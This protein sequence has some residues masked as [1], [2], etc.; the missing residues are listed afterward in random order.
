MDVSYIICA[1]Y[2][3]CRCGF[4]YPC[5]RNSFGLVPGKLAAENWVCVV[6]KGVCNCQRCKD[7]I[8]EDLHK[9]INHANNGPVA[10]NKGDEEEEEILVVKQWRREPYLRNEKE[11]KGPKSY[12]PPRRAAK[13]PQAESEEE[14]SEGEEEGPSPPE[15]QGSQ[16]VSDN[17]SDYVPSLKSHRE[18]RKKGRAKHEPH[19]HLHPHQHHAKKDDSSTKRRA[20]GPKRKPTIPAKPAPVA[21]TPTSAPVPVRST[22]AP[23]KPV[24][25][26]SPVQAFARPETYFYPTMAPYASPQ[27]AYAAA[28]GAEMAARGIPE[29]S[30]P[31]YA[32]PA[33]SSPSL[34]GEYQPASAMYPSFT[35]AAMAAA[36][37][38]GYMPYIMAGG[39][40]LMSSYGIMS[41]DMGAYAAVDPSAFYAAA[42]PTGTEQPYTV[43]AWP[44]AMASPMAGMAAGMTGNGREQRKDVA[45]SAPAGTADGKDGKLKN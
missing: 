23:V 38:S 27:M 5:L 13:R 6:C 19:A 33:I 16:S 29:L 18:K 28:A 43:Y 10:D 22:V 20:P 40:S 4:C 36:G 2:P 34:M 1:N 8:K 21:A 41:P 44:G 3:K 32:G 15:S 30:L 14:S 39:D 31:G 37:Q 7:R 26:R 17:S 9:I 24:P 45:A 11:F 25:L 35:S 12:E 42:A